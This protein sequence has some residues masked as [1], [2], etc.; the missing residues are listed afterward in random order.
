MKTLG[1]A[2]STTYKGS[3]KSDEEEDDWASADENEQQE[4]GVGPEEPK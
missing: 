1:E 4:R 2:P 3:G